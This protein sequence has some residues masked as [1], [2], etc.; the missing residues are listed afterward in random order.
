MDCLS[1]DSGLCDFED[2]LLS[3]FDLCKH[4]AFVFIPLGVSDFLHDFLIIDTLRGNKKTL[5]TCVPSRKQMA[6][7]QRVV[8]EETL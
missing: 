6:D 7:S 5:Y 8:N 3:E 4:A 2:V 1:S